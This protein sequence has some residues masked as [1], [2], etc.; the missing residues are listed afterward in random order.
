[1]G[2]HTVCY[3]MWKGKKRSFYEFN[4][5][6]RLGP[7]IRPSLRRE[8][9]LDD[10]KHHQR[11]RRHVPGSTVFRLLWKQRQRLLSDRR[12]VPRAFRQVTVEGVRLPTPPPLFPPAMDL[13]VA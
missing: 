4:G 8:Q 9:Q 5:D 13:V 6:E 10:A 7:G 12:A 1:M 3:V 11:G 2:W